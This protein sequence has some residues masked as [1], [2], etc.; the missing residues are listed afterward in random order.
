MDHTKRKGS[1]LNSRWTSPIPEHKPRGSTTYTS[2]D[3]YGR[4][5]IPEDSPGTN[6]NYIQEKGRLIP[7][8]Y[9]CEANKKFPDH[10]SKQEPPISLRQIKTTRT[11]REKH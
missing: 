5:S 10:S 3:P 2:K 1:Y 7:R 8:Q 6:F 9:S 4:Q 11:L